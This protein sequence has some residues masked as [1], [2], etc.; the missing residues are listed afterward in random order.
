MN[1]E[2]VLSECDPISE[3]DEPWDGED[4]YHRV[5]AIITDARETFTKKDGNAMGI[6][7]AEFEGQEISFAVF[8]RQWGSHRFLF[9]QRTVAVLK[10]RH[11]ERGIHFESGT[12]L[13]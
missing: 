2:D 7:K 1:N 11:T 3:L 9:K 6:V 8:P 13:T 12:R 5:C 4:T 10:L